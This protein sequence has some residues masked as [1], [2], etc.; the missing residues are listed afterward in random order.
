LEVELNEENEMAHENFNLPYENC[1][2]FSGLGPKTKN[3][4]NKISICPNSDCARLF[5]TIGNLKTHIKNHHEE[6]KRYKCTFQECDKSYVNVC[7]VKTH[8]RIH[9]SY[10]I[11]IKFCNFI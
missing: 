9:V 4:F 7:R 11:K 6:N 8:L 10:K 1:P 3:T 2:K 5:T